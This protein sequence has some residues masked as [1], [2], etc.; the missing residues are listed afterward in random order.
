MMNNI[1]LFHTTLNLLGELYHSHFGLH[2]NNDKYLELASSEME[3]S[4][5]K[6]IIDNDLLIQ[7]FN[8]DTNMLYFDGDDDDLTYEMIEDNFCIF[9]LKYD[10]VNQ[11]LKQKTPFNLVEIYTPDAWTIKPTEEW[12]NMNSTWFKNNPKVLPYLHECENI[13]I[14]DLFEKVHIFTTATK[15]K[16]TYEDILMGTRG[17]MIDDTR[18][19]NGGFTIVNIDADNKRIIL[20]PD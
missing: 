5:F 15:D 20:I 7:C 18:I 1:E 19:V 11:L 12:C 6:F 2:L 8:E 9:R 13:K 14:I 10:K 3:K 17:V 4:Q 16:I